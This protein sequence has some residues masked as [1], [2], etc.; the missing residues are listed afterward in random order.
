[1]LKN[2]GAK[3]TSILYPIP[4]GTIDKMG[5]RN[6]N[7]NIYHIGTLNE[8]F[9]KEILNKISLIG[10]N[11]KYNF[12]IITNNLSS[13]TE[14]K[15]SN[16]GSTIIKPIKK[17]TDLFNKLVSEADLLIVFYSSDLNLE[18]RSIYSFPSKFIELTHLL[19]PIIIISPKESAISKWCISNK[20]LTYIDNVD[21]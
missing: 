1:L 21:H 15:L 8:N 6:S 17:T 11:F 13:E 18:R 9:H 5:E 4:E 10:L 20:W 16:N 3:S 7:R 14:K 12:K 19:I 2:N